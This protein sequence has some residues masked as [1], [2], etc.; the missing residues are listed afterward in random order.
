MATSCN[1]TALTCCGCCEGITQETP[2]TLQNRPGLSAVAHR[3]GTY[4]QFY[5][6]LL[7]RISQSR[8]PSLRQLRSREPD[9]F[10]IALLDAFSVMGDVLTFYTERMANESYLDTATQRQ[11]V[12]E[13]ANLVGYRMSP[14]VAASAYL[15]FTIDPAA[16]AFGS[17]LTAAVN[18]QVVP[19][20][21]PST[22][23]PVGTQ[24]QSIP[25]PGQTPQTFET[26]EQIVARADWN[27]ISPRLFQ[28]QAVGAGGNAVLLS[29]SVSN[30][31]KGDPLLIVPA[32]TSTSPQLNSVLSIII[33]AD[34]LTTEVDL[35]G[36]ATPAPPPVYT[37]TV[38]FQDDPSAGSTSLTQ[39]S[40]STLQS[41]PDLPTV[42]GYLASQT[43]WWDAG[44]VVAAATANQWPL[45][46][47][48]AIVNQQVAAATPPAGSVYAFRQ[49]AAPFGFNS[50]NYYSLQP[51]LRF[52]SVFLEDTP[53][54]PGTTFAIDVPAAYPVSAAWDPPPGGS[55][56]FTLSQWPSGVIYLDN[57]YSQIVPGSYIALLSGSALS[58]FTVGATRTVTFSQ[59]STTGKVT[60]LTISPINSSQPS[61]SNFGLRNTV[62]LCQGEALPLAQ[63][64]ITSAN[65]GGAKSTNVITLSGAFLGL[66][67]GQQ[68]VLSGTTVV[69]NSSGGYSTGPVAAE[70]R[71]LQQVE[72]TGGFTVI[73]LDSVLGN[74]YQRFTVSINAN[75]ASATNGRTVAELLGNGDG[76]QQFQSFVLH[77][78]PLTYVQSDT[79]AG[80]ASTLQVWVD[81]VLW[82]EAPYFYGRS[83]GEHIY[84]TSQD[85]NGVTT[86]TFGDG[87]T[88]SRLPTGAANV[89]ATYRFGIGTAGL[90]NANQLSQL[91]SR[92]LGVRGVNNPLAAS[93]AA[94]PEDLDSGRDRAT[95]AI[96]TLGRAVSLQDYQDFALATVGIGKALATWT[97]DGQKR[98][99]VLTIAGAAGPIDPTDS[100]LTSL[101]KAIASYSE[102][103][104]QL[105][106]FSYTPLYFN[107]NASV[108]ISVDYQIPGVQSAIESAL[109]QSFGFSAR[110]FGQPVYQS[111]VIAV[112]QAIA[113][114]VDVVLTLH[115]SNDPL[116]TPETQ[117]AASVPQ[118][119]GRDQI[120][121]AQ[122][123][124]L[125]PGTLG[126]TVT[127]VTQ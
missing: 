48:S 36:Q 91:M 2:Q 100:V 28:P 74:I 69:Q 10:T 49:Q 97:W 56:G 94:D 53:S 9:D 73:T 21:V 55:G 15:A 43:N 95:L 112:I 22:I 105:Y 30:L 54:S 24:V 42:A 23:V 68:I 47:L 46:S 4:V 63:I 7:A 34:G 113:G 111:E 12:R 52:P 121:A 82:S 37:P 126:V 127:T 61:L 17:V 117:L 64:P 44:D 16:G 70:V 57:V 19:E 75:V 99:V 14:G 39:G 62:I 124:T 123:L 96:M 90:V 79:I 20:L 122:L 86:V 66:L 87:I 51:A 76:T 72:I 45:D 13:L 119:G 40:L 89:S 1:S 65:I 104:V 67:A 107:L 120:S 71:T 77:Q 41:A 85:D 84:V 27:A 25:G 114:V 3:V 108:Q 38:I 60:Q 83:P 118:S 6:T 78:S 115:L 110:D 98:V 92:P 93:G 31:K 106:L 11:S 101:P 125:D 5:E 26:V 58:I 88:G 109:R 103:G 50:P 29:G 81:G 32:G 35:A 102:P 18:A 80:S 116:Q 59:F 33:A 8:Q